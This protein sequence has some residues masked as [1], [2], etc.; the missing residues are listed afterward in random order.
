MEL[1]T[2]E[3]LADKIIIGLTVLYLMTEILGGAGL[4]NQWSVGISWLLVIAAFVLYKVKKGEKQAW[5]NSVSDF[6]LWEKGGFL[7]LCGLLL[8]IG[9]MAVLTVPYN[10]DSMTYHLTRAAHWIQDGSVDYFVT[11]NRRQLISPVLSEY[12]LLHIMLL[13]KGDLFVNCLQFFSL[14]VC[15]MLAFYMMRRLGVSRLVCFGGLVLAITAP[16]ILGEA[17]STQTDLVAAMCLMLAVHKIFCFAF[18]G[19]F[20][21]DKNTCRQIVLTG[22]SVGLGYL[23]KPSVC[24]S[25]LV[26]MLWLLAV[27]VKRKI[28]IKDLSLFILTGAVSTFILPV[29]VFFRNMEY[30]GDPFAL[31]YMSGIGVGSF[32]PGCLILN[33]YKNFASLAALKRNKG[34]LLAV[35]NELADL[36]GIS[37][38]DPRI[39]YGNGSFLYEQNL[40]FSYDHDFAGA[41]IFLL[42][43]IM[44]LIAFVIWGR[45]QRGKGQ[46]GFIVA[47]MLQ[48]FV[49]LCVVRWQPWVNRLLLP[50]VILTVIPLAWFL[51]KAADGIAAKKAADNNAPNDFQNVITACVL[52]LT[53]LLFVLRPMKFHM[54][55]VNRNLRQEES[56][57][58]LYFAKR[59]LRET[60]EN[61][62]SLAYGAQNVGIYAS[63]DAYEYPLWVRLKEQSKESVCIQNIVPGEEIKDFMPECI[64]VLDNI[65][66]IY[67]YRGQT[68]KA[69]WIESTGLYSILYP[70]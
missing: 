58:E 21:F 19:N 27:C 29:P 69:V 66:P 28:R 11:N 36:L 37:I 51:Q 40:V 8:I 22:L 53:A 23:A 12:V 64:I 10:W 20:A 54:N 67:E 5:R 34:L 2:I 9:I 1:K 47:V 4:L 68:Y 59:D 48:F 52:V 18:E 25:I 13:T 14:A 61:L 44:A 60:Y 35:G 32:H 24:Y 16:L 33:G 39:T 45:K 31:S 46:T 6:S 70:E 56:R 30:A 62:S 17:L 63:A 42:F 50:T 26:L 41:G 7:I 43:L 65:C 3:K 38:N 57:W 15:V 49:N 55:Y